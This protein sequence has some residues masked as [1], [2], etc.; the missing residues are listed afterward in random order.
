MKFE[1]RNPKL[2][3]NSNSK[4]RNR[5]GAT[6]LRPFSHSNFEF[7]SSFGFR[8]SNFRASGFTLVELIVVIGIIAVLIGILLPVVGRVRRA[9]YMADTENEISQISNACNQYYSAY[10]AYPGPIS[11]DQIEG[12]CAVNRVRPEPFLTYYYDTTKNPPAYTSYS[13]A[14]FVTGTENLVLGL[15]GGLRLNTAVETVI[16]G[17]QYN[18]GLTFAPTEVGLGP[19]NLNPEN[20][21]RTPSFF[22][23]GSTYLMWCES[24]QKTGAGFQTTTYQAANS[25]GTALFPVPFTDQTGMVQS[26]DSPIPEFVDRFPA[27][28]PMPI[29][30]LRA[31]LSAPGTLSFANGANSG[32]PVKVLDPTQTQTPGEYQYDLGDIYPYTGSQIGLAPGNLHDLYAVGSTTTYPPT[33]WPPPG[34]PKAGTTNSPDGFNYFLNSSVNPTNTTDVNYYGRPRA[35]D[36]FILISAGPDGIYGTADDITSFGSFSQ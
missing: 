29:L 31:R 5:P 22:P 7:D 4:I 27:P 18:Y 24:T 33:S 10:Q 26:K 32:Q 9:A 23:A 14:Y 34:P 3:S 2:E 21:S 17:V 15:M 6:P 36:Q 16:N 20:P 12:T 35:V 1:T 11:N 25:N 19:L 30:Y 8:V 13:P 28:G